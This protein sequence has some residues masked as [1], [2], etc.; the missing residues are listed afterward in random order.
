MTFILLI[1]DVCSSSPLPH[2]SFDVP[3]RDLPEPAVDWN[4]FANRISELND[5]T[6]LV[7]NP[8]T[9]RVTKWIDMTAL[10]NKY[11]K[12]SKAYKAANKKT[13][14]GK[15]FHWISYCC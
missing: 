13:Q 8:I 9:K 7:F 5:R 6:P 4:A 11:G 1:A 3:V 12:N 15:Q 10:N 2:S 14:K